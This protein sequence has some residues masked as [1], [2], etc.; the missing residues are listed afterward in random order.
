MAALVVLASGVDG[1]SARGDEPSEEYRQGLQRTLQL[2]K[3]RRRAP[4][5]APGVIIGYPM[6]PALVIRQRPE[7]HEEI[8]AFLH[9]LRYGGR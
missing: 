3:L 8:A 9:L 2:R 4:T 5:P 7:T 1:R 6:P